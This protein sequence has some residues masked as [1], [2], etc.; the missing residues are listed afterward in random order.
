MKVAD[1]I[2]TRSIV[3]RLYVRVASSH[4]RGCHSERVTGSR[5][6]TRATASARPCARVASVAPGRHL[7]EHAAP[8]RLSRHH[9]AAGRLAAA[10]QHY[11]NTIRA[12]VHTLPSGYRSSLL[13]LSLR[14]PALSF[15]SALWVYALIAYSVTPTAPPNSRLKCQVVAHRQRSRR[16]WAAVSPR[17]K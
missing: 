8:G 11:C 14:S 17:R 10:L 12:D 13:R 2:R 9:R 5:T 16:I 3:N 7:G 6:I 1:L 15:L 4:R